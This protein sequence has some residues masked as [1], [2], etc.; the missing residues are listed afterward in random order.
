MNTIPQNL[1]NA[2]QKLTEEL[3]Q[4]CEG[5]RTK[6]RLEELEKA[7]YRL[8]RLIGDKRKISELEQIL[9]L[10]QHLADAA[11]IA[12]SFTGSHEEKEAEVYLNVEDLNVYLPG[13]A[14]FEC[15]GAEV[16]RLITRAIAPEEYAE[17]THEHECGNSYA[18]IS[19]YGMHYL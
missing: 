8:A 14:K 13:T 15:L 19:L 18:T 3:A 7:F 10:Y 1:I 9:E 16:L 5:E 4:T 11:N 6:T 2:A 12:A 17:L